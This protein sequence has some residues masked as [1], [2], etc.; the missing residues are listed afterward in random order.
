MEGPESFWALRFVLFFNMGKIT[1]FLYI[2]GNGLVKREN[3]MM[4]YRGEGNS[5][6]MPLSMNSREGIRSN[7]SVEELI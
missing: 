6:A 7:T 2:D 5:G 1:G 3:L 4:H